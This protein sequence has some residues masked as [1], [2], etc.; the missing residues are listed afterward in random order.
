MPG[1]ELVNLIRVGID[2][3]AVA[4]AAGLMKIFLR[5]ND[6]KRNQRFTEG[7]RKL[8]ASHRAACDLLLAA[9]QQP[10]EPSEV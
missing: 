4:H 8:A 10:E 1:Q 6:P 7:V 5:P 3:Q 9:A 2:Q